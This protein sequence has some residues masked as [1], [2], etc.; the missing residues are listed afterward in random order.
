MTQFKKKKPKM[1]ALATRWSGN[2]ILFGKPEHIPIIV[3]THFRSVSA[4]GNIMS[5]IIIPVSTKSGLT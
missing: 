4:T 1:L 3:I 2:G 5:V